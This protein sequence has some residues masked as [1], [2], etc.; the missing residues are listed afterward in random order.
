MEWTR[1]KLCRRHNN[2]FPFKTEYEARSTPGE[3]RW[4]EI[5]W[6]LNSLTRVQI[7]ALDISW[8]ATFIL[9]NGRFS[10][11][12]TVLSRSTFS[13]RGLLIVSPAR[14]I[15]RF[16]R[17]VTRFYRAAFHGYPS[18]RLYNG[19]SVHLAPPGSIFGILRYSGIFHPLRVPEWA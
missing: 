2:S 10:S 16:I 12:W 11:R 17:P 14:A 4:K 3:G 9:H 7:G 19:V 5:D 1:L 15:F 6:F 8:C 13:F 18:R